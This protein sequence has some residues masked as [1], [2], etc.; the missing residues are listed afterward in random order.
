MNPFR[1]HQSIDKFSVIHIRVKIIDVIIFS[2]AI[3][4]NDPLVS[5]NAI[6]PFCLLLIKTASV[7]LNL[8]V[9]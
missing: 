9:L 3:A 5:V 8:P 7:C 2:S 6:C 1:N 4:W